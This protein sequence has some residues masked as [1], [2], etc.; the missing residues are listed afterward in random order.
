MKKLALLALL[1]L[2]LATNVGCTNMSRTHQGA[3]S[4]AAIGA[5][6]GLG[7]AAISGGVVGTGA[8]AGAIIGGIAGGAVGYQQERQW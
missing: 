6:G 2:T 7:I 4:G 1:A 5:A 8:L 3:L